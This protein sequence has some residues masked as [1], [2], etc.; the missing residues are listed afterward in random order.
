V[1]GANPNDVYATGDNGTILRWNGT[2]WSSMSSGTTDQLWSVSGAP[3]GNGA[4]FAVGFN[5]TLVAATS[6]GGMVV[7][8]Y[9]ALVA[10]RNVDLDP[11]VGAK[12]VRGPLPEGK[13]RD[14][15]KGR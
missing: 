8:G 4:G 6:S 15:R 3:S 11:Q 7:S 12:L 14:H 9:R 5:S 1:W 2:S 13:A 10:A